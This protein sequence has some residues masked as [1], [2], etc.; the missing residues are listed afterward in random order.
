MVIQA[1]RQSTLAGSCCARRHCL[2][3]VM[4]RQRPLMAALLLSSWTRTTAPLRTPWP[5]NGFVSLHLRHQD[6][7]SGVRAGGPGSEG[8]GPTGVG[9]ADIRATPCWPPL[10]GTSKLLVWD[11][12]DPELRAPG[13]RHHPEK[14]RT[15]VHRLVGRAR[16]HAAVTSSDLWP[17]T[18]R[19][20]QRSAEH[21]AT[22]SH[23]AHHMLAAKC[24]CR[25]EDE[26]VAR[27][28]SHALP[29]TTPADGA[30]AN[31]PEVESTN[32]GMM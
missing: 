11:G 19:V 16:S 25:K 5:H 31:K 6:M 23:G 9:Q 4:V 17:A 27:A 12:V 29:A 22:D 18:R 2:S 13:E 8:N 28:C 26:Y 20:S 32:Q 15:V 1:Q 3:L 24:G 7:P 21:F 10:Y 14:S 30:C